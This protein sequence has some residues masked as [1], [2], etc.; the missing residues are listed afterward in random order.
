MAKIFNCKDFGGCCHW[1]VRAETLEE[2]LA[3]VARHGALKHNMKGMTNDMKTKI[4]SL[5]REK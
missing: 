5:I 3:K 1:K 4:I 2:L